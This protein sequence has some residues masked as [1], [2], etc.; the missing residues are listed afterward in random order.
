MAVFVDVAR[1]ACN[2]D[3]PV[4]EHLVMAGWLGVRRGGE[5]V[6]KLLPTRQARPTQA[7]VSSTTRPSYTILTL[8]V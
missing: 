5:V 6:T 2:E 1:K 7:D 4:A 8:I 3:M